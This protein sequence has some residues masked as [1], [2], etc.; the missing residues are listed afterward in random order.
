MKN[1]EEV[2][3][4]DTKSK[5]WLL[6]AIIRHLFIKS[7]HIQGFVYIEDTPAGEKPTYCSSTI[8]W[9]EK[10]KIE[11]YSEKRAYMLSWE[12]FHKK[13]P[14]FSHFIQLF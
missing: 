6:P 8:H 1:K 10:L 5:I 2:L 14:Q 4:Q 3:I 11:T 13:Y 7:Y 12:F 9:F